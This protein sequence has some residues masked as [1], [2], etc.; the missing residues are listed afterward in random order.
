M[1]RPLCDGSYATFIFASVEPA[2]YASEISDYLSRYSGSQYLR[3][4]VTCLSL[5]QRTDSGAVIYAVFFGPFPTFE[6]ACA[7]VSRGPSGSYVK[8][9]DNVSDPDEIP[10]CG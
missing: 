6:E 10:A 3:T 5:R 7:A 2:R 4:D 8:P 1:A 9:L